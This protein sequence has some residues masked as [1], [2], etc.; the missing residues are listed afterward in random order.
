MVF[1]VIPELCNGCRLCA[2]ICSEQ[3]TG[4]Y[5]DEKNSNFRIIEMQH[6]GIFEA[7]A[8]FNVETCLKCIESNCGVPICSQ[9]CPTGALVYGTISEVCEKRISFINAKERNLAYSFVAPWKYKDG[10]QKNDL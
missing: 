7:V 8:G 10:E 6:K 5:G 2:S 4:S 1:Y 3:N 9:K